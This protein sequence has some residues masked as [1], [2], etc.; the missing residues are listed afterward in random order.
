MLS[1]GYIRAHGCGGHWQ[2]SK[3]IGI[4]CLCQFG[5]DAAAMPNSRTQHASGRW[6][7]MISRDDFT[8]WMRTRDATPKS[9]M[10]PSWAST[11][12]GGGL[13][14]S[15]LQRLTRGVCNPRGPGIVLR[16]RPWRRSAS[17]SCTAS[18]LRR[19]KSPKAARIADVLISLLTAFK[20]EACLASLCCLLRGLPVH[21]ALGTLRSTSS[22]SRF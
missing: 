15:L 1:K 4:S 19:E 10:R 18:R 11:G 2:S 17:A 20:V 14:N 6:I 9:V 13:R 21:A 3:I 8:P 12:D 5:G 16:L 7:P 22:H